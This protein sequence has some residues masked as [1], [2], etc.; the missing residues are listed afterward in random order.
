[1][2]ADQGVQI[3]I[4]LGVHTG[5]VVVGEM[6]SG[7]RHEHLA[8]G[9]TPNIAAR[10]EGLAEANT[11]VISAVTARLVQRDFILEELGTRELKGVA[12][13]MSI[14]RVEGIREIDDEIAESERLE[15]SDLVGRDEEIGLLLRRWTQ[16]K[17]GLG[18]I[19]LISGEAGMGKSSLIDGLRH[20]VRED[21]Y[22]CMTF[23]CSPYTMNSSLFPI[24]DHIQRVLGWQSGEAEET[25]LEKLEQG[26][27]D[28]GLILQD[29]V[30]LLAALLDLSLPPGRYTTLDLNPQQQRQQTQDAL[31]AW[32]LAEADRQPILAVWEDL[33]YR[34]RRR[35]HAVIGR[36]RMPDNIT[37]RSKSCA[38]RF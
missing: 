11:M 33:H 27:Q 5:P 37:H 6:G 30:P 2:K 1:L 3:A 12:S 4:R 15:F 19:V 13:P 38:A 24:I 31:T 18:Q 23:R 21:G 14:F 29:A 9:E 20:N 7:E 26:L 25:K 8:L 28:A 22:T 17:A 36:C 34:N 10:L 35:F 16:S 32:L